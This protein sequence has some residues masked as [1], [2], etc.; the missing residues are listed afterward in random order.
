MK[1]YFKILFLI[2]IVLISGCEKNTEIP[3][4]VNPLVSFALPK[5]IFTIAVTPNPMPPGTT[6]QTWS[7]TTVNEVDFDIKDIIYRIYAPDSSYVRGYAFTESEIKALFEYVYIPPCTTI[8]GTRA[9]DF[10]E[11]SGYRAAITVSGIDENQNQ[12]S[13]SDT[14]VIQ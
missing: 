5:S 6:T 4:P 8:T 2:T 9:N 10:T 12:V 7:V 1:T 3:L 11:P 14:V 13:S